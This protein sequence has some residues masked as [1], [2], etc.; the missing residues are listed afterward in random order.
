MK[1]RFPLIPWIDI[2]NIGNHIRHAY[3]SVDAEIL[4]N[5]YRYELGALE[6]AV[7]EM[8]LQARDDGSS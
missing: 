4:W 5:V 7:A 8:K 3:D 6:A 2:A 1:A